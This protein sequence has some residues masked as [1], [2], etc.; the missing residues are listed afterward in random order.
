M[1][2]PEIHVAPP[3]IAQVGPVGVTNAMFT[4]F[5][6]SGLMML[7]AL[8]MNR[9]VKLIPGR[10]QM[11]IE[12]VMDFFLKKLEMTLGCEKKARRLMPFIVTVFIF[13][14][15][16]NQFMLLP[17]VGSVL[18]GDQWLFKTPTAHYSLPIALVV[19]GLGFAH[20]AA[21]IMHPI[22]HLSNYFKFQVFFKMK[23]LKELPMA[24]IEFF[25]GLMDIIGELS[26][27]VSVSTRLFG[28]M[29]AGE[30]IIIIISGLL[31]IT[32]F[33]FPI[34]FLILGILSGLV[35]AFVF[36]MLLTLFMGS[37]FNGVAP[38]ESNS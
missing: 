3:I 36:A 20:I 10:A 33:I 13:L 28:N 23:S 25:L 15:L 22:R 5:V 32:Q 1:N 16:C 19:M 9:K 6:I 30:L 34:P 4:A 35:Q 12:M 27:F 17:M 7:F 14:F 11:V 37:T 24:M 8:V 18:L 31:F 38:Q 21:F 2:I 29:L 26:K